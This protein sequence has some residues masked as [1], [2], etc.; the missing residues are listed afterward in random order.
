MGR[1][2]IATIETL[3]ILGLVSMVT[4]TFASTVVRTAGY[5]GIFW[6]EEITRYISIWVVFLASGLGVRYGIHLSVDMVVALLPPPRIRPIGLGSSRMID[7][8]VIDLPE[9]DS[10]TR[11][12]TEPGA[13]VSPTLRRIGVPPIVRSRSRTCRSGAGLIGA[14]GITGPVV[15]RRPGDLLDSPRRC[16]D[17]VRA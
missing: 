16:P 7:S 13:T 5:G 12:R 15:R 14:P 2:Y 6:A 3:I 11:P 9:P 17:Q 1:V 4:L 10:P 8:A